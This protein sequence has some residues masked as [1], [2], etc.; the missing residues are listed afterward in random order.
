MGTKGDKLSNEAALAADLFVERLSGLSRITSKKMF[1][2]F[3]IFCNNQMFGIVN[4]EGQVFLKAED[5]MKPRFEK[6]GSVKHSRMPYYSIPEE[7]F[8]NLEQFTS[9]AKESILI[10]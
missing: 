10:K 6:L 7:I 9:W 2:G 3:G 5:K 4:S 8:N 1:G